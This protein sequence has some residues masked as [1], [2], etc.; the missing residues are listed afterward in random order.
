MV[1]DLNLDISGVGEVL[2][3]LLDV[4]MWTFQLSLLAP[5][6]M[7]HP[8][9]NTYVLTSFIRNIYV[10]DLLFLTNVIY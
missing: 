8:A 9:V 10:W 4:T 6:D 7:A 5:E 1:I 3:M 2:C